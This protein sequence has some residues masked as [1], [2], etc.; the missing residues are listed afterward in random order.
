MTSHLSCIA[1][2]LYSLNQH[3][4]NLR[5]TRSNSP[6]IKEA[7]IFDISADYQANTTRERLLFKCELAL[8]SEMLASSIAAEFRFR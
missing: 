3:S 7:S 1:S 8:L 5:L 2:A 4:G 6:L